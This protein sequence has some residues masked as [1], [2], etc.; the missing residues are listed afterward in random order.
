MSVGTRIKSIFSPKQQEI[1]VESDTDQYLSD[2]A[3]RIEDALNGGYYDFSAAIGNIRNASLAFPAY[4]RV[5]TLL[6]SM[7]AQLITGGSLRVYDREGRQVESKVVDDLKRLLEWSPDGDTPASQWI[8]DL[9]CDYL[10]DG[11][12]LI[13]VDHD[14][15]GSRTDYYGRP[16]YKN[17]RRFNRLSVWDANCYEDTGGQTVYKARYFGRNRTG[18]EHEFRAR[19]V[20]HVRWPLS[21]R[22]STTSQS[23][24]WNFAPAPVRLMRAALEIGL[25]S[26]EYITTFY[27]ESNH[28]S[29]GIA[30]KEDNIDIKDMKAINENINSA[31]KGR[32]PITLPGDGTFYNLKNLA[33]NKDLEMLRRFQVEDIARV[34]GIPGPV[35]GANLTQWGQGI[36]ELNK[37][38]WSQCLHQHIN[39]VLAPLQFKFLEPGQQM[40]IDPIDFTKGDLA[41]TAALITATIGDAQ[42][43]Q[44]ATPQ[45]ARRWVD[46][47]PQPADG[48]EL[49]RASLDAGAADNTQNA[50]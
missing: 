18:Q 4:Y 37:M 33:S 14:W 5:V 32:R 44:V 34:Y 31:F 39:R 41:A 29:I 8:E 16:M 1:P 2:T 42:R 17:I 13:Q 15:D 10:I 24:R 9:C 28:S 26:D 6:S 20:A 40:D 22:T 7:V 27:K 45:E 46:L 35:A 12:G 25:A 19:E 11:N 3:Q 50:V 49:R 23:N 43:D 36:S 48:Q 21:L 30:L 47:P 38:F